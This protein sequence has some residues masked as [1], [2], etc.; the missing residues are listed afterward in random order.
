LYAGCLLTSFRLCFEVCL[1]PAWHRPSWSYL[2]HHLAVAYYL[3]RKARS[4]EG[5]AFR[6]SDAG[7]GGIAG[8]LL[9]ALSQGLELLLMPAREYLAKWTAGPKLDHRR[10]PRTCCCWNASARARAPAAALASG[11]SKRWSKSSS[12]SGTS[13]HNR[14]TYHAVPAS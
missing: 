10:P 6:S 13:T 7:V 9:L 14:M 8:V 4:N 5:V 11:A 3:S 1:V 12:S 2:A